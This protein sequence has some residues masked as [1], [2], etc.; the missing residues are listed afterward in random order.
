MVGKPFGQGS[1][2]GHWRLFESVSVLSVL[3][4]GGL[5]LGDAL[6]CVLAPV[7]A[8]GTF[9]SS[10]QSTTE[11]ASH[12]LL[13]GEYL[14]LLP[15]VRARCGFGY[16]FGEQSRAR[17]VC[18]HRS[19]FVSLLVYEAA[20]RIKALRRIGQSLQGQQLW[21]KTLVEHAPRSD[22]HPA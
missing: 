1:V 20:C 5:D 16:G 2:Q 19:A 22:W 11:I 4:C 14:D 15:A 7:E 21:R 9:L 18:E 10:H 13:V 8:A 6:V 3:L 12:G 17:T